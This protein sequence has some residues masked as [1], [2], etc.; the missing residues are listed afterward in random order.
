MR[1]EQK[2]NDFQISK[3]CRAKYEHIRVRG[4][5][6]G[7]NEDRNIGLMAGLDANMINVNVVFIKCTFVAG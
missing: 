2:K 7:R 4:E 6:E 5:E 1:V 3:Y